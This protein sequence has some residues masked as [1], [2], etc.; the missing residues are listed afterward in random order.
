MEM[1]LIEPFMVKSSFGV[2]ADTAVE[3]EAK[4]G[5]SLL[6][7]DVIVRGSDDSYVLLEIEKTTVGFFRVDNH[8]LGSHLYP[9]LGFSG[10]SH[11]LDITSSSRSDAAIAYEAFIRDAL[12]YS[13]NTQLV[14]ID[15]PAQII[16]R[17]FKY[18]YT[19][20]PPTTLLAY[21]I[22]KGWMRGYPVAEG[23]TFRV[24]PFTSG[25]KLNDVMIIYEKYDAGDIKATDP[26]GSESKEY[27]FVNYGRPRWDLKES[28][29]YEVCVC[30]TT[31]EFPDFPF[32]KSVPSRTTIEILGILGTESLMYQDSGNYT[33]TKYLKM[34]K[35]R[36]CLF[37]RDKQGL[38]FYQFIPS[39]ASSG[40]YYG[41]GF[42]VIGN[43]SAIDRREPFIPPKPLVFGEGEE[44]KVFVTVEAVGGSITLYKQMAEIGFI[45]RVKVAE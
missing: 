35:G 15:D 19:N 42:S 3:L 25:K 45:E 4:T 5:E 43:Y 14:A 34:F 41:E 7:K 21:L 33:R 24:K 2:G 9:P 11:T 39:D 6:V 37:D 40:C 44:V 30:V 10:H 28:K 27:V 1:A 36:T 13:H 17:A 20:L 31:E 18:A 22:K 26:N 16:H 12:G 23:Q 29:D 32:G 38:P 8:Y